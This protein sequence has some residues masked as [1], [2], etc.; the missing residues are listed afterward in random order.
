MIK[1]EDRRQK[2][3]DRI[4]AKDMCITS[5]SYSGK[6]DMHSFGYATPNSDILTSDSCLLSSNFNRLSSSG[7]LASASLKK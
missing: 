4:I 7:L 3:E 2:S 5:G 1:Q 6:P